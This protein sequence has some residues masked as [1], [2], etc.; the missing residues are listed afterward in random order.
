[1]A[2]TNREFGW[3]EEISQDSQFVLLPDG[4]YDFMVTG[5]ERARY[6]G[7][8]KIPACNMAKLAIDITVPGGESVTINHQMMLYTTL[9]WK[10]CEFFLGIGLRKKGEPLRMPWNQVIGRRGRCKI[11]IRKYDGKEYN[12]IKKFYDP[13]DQPVQGGNAPAAGGYSAGGIW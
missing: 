9:E 6:K 1:M 2:D 3:E 4:D 13:A 12:E 8:D 5:F 11:G 10:L 7:G